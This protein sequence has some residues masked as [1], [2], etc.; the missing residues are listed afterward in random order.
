MPEDLILTTPEIV[1]QVTTTSYRVVGLSLDWERTT[2][3][4]RVRGSNGEV[5]TFVYG[6]S[7]PSTPQAAKDKATA[8]MIALNKANLSVKSLQRRVL[9]Q[10]ATDGLLVGGVTGAPD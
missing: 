8:L 1:P 2:I 3:V 4:I 7:D 5:K 9:E 10:L 6:G